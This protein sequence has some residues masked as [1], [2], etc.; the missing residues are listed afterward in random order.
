MQ[1]NHT[2]TKDTNQAVLQRFALLRHFRVFRSS[3]FCKR[4][5][6]GDIH[7]WPMT[8]HLKRTL[9]DR[10]LNCLYLVAYITYILNIQLLLL[11]QFSLRW[12]LCTWKSPYVLHP[13]SQK[14]PQS[15]LWNGSSVHLTDD[16]HRFSLVQS[17]VVCILFT[18]HGARGCTLCL[19]VLDSTLPTLC[20]NA[21][22]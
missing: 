1:I 15:C 5:S 17:G 20:M 19:Q 22:L 9:A 13:V 10:V 4:K 12:Y 21:G 8:H 18:L 16:G 6:N 3:P 11:P 2:A 7:R 14:F